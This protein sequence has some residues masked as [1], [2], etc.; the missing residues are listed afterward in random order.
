MRLAAARLAQHVRVHD[1]VLAGLRMVDV[2]GGP[3]QRVA[4]RIA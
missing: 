1:G 3:G 4:R 2:A